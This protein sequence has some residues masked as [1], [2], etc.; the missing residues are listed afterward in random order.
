VN[1]SARGAFAPAALA[2]RNYDNP[3]K[4]SVKMY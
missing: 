1:L 3:Y 2:P 4:N